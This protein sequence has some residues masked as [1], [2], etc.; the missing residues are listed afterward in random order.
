[1]QKKILL[2]ILISSSVLLTSHFSMAKPGNVECIAPAGAGGGWDFTCRVPAAQV[3]TQLDLVDSV[4]VT[5]MSGAGGGKAYA[6]VVSERG[7]DQ[8]LIVAGSTATAARLAQNVYSGFSADDVRWAGALG[9]DYGVV[10]VGKDSNFQSLGEL[11]NALKDNPRR[12][13][14]VGASSKGGWDHLKFLLVAKEAQYP[15]LSRINYIAFDNGGQALLEVISGR[16][17]AFTGDVSELLSQEKADNIKVLA[18]LAPERLD[19]LP[20][21]P[22]AKELGYDVIGANWRAFYV[23]KNIPDARYSQ[24]VDII[25]NVAE[26]EEWQDLRDKNGLAEFAMYGEEFEEFVSNQVSDIK[27]ISEELGFISQ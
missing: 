2:P 19:V 3:M 26:S 24:W 6:Y 8:D 15:D 18:V 21:V 25:K 17:A 4:R 10:A 14:I 12:N 11:I 7:D 27:S 5:N 13:S 16:A 1:M 23:P 20:D 22:T 9:S